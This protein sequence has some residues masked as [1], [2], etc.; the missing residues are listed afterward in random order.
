MRGDLFARFTKE[1]ANRIMMLMLHY[2]LDENEYQKVKM[3][4]HNGTNFNIDG[5]INEAL[6]KNL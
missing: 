6:N 2:Y 1:E 5:Y 4:N 3:F